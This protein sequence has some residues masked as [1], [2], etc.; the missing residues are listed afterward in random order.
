MLRLEEWMD[1]RTLHREGHSIKEIARQTGRSRNTVRR[2][3]REAGPT[4]FNKPE[5]SSCLDS[6]RPYLRERFETSALSAVRFLPEIQAMGY[7]GSLCTLRRYL[8]TLRPEQERLKKLTVR[9]ETPPG[10]QA[11][12]DWAYC[13]R[14]P[15]AAGQIVPVYAFVMVLSFSRMLYVE[16]TSSM[17]LPVLIRC[18]MKAFEFYGGWPH[19]ILYDN[20]KQVRLSQHELNP[21]FADFANHYGFAAKTHRIRRPRTKGKV[22]RMVHYV[23][24]AFLNGRTFSDFADLNAQAQHWLAHTANARVHATTRQRPLDLRL[25]EGLTVL[26]SIAPYKLAELVS[27]KAGFDGFVRFERSRYSLPPEYAGQ[28]VLIGQRDNRIVIRAQ[29]MIVAEHAPAQKA[30]ASVADPAHIEA[31]WKLSLKNTAAPPPRWQLS[32]HQQVEA[33]PLTAYQEAVQ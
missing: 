2:V 8:H 30:G 21:L 16:F 31:L 19:E 25:R 4:G 22:E 13:G 6:F 29:D 28:N 7:T 23:K 10:K 3:L 32:F 17:H 27:R 24:D 11:Q 26:N 1:V 5:R 12:A 15:D 9:F 18:H 20:M 33:A 14:F